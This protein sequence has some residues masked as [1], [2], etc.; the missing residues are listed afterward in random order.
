M[1]LKSYPAEEQGPLGPGERLHD[2]PFTLPDGR[3]VSLYA[4]RVFGWPVVMHVA[5]SPEAAAEGCAAL[6]DRVA[7]FAALEARLY[8]VTAGADADNGAL[9]E[10][11]G[12]PFPVLGDGGW[13]IFQALAHYRPA[14]KMK[15]AITLV[16]DPILRLDAVFDEPDAAQQCL[17]ALTW[18]Q[19]RR[20]AQPPSV[21]TAQPPALVVPRV[22]QPDQCQRL[23][24][25][26]EQGQKTEGY[27]TS[28]GAGGNV[29]KHRTKV[30]RDVV[31]PEGSA[32]CQDLIGSIGRRLL[33]EVL[34]GFGYR[35]T[36]IETPRIGCY[37]AEDG[38]HFAA[39][40]DNTARQAEY[41]RF[42]MSLNLNSGEYEGGYLRF[43]EFGPQLYA[44]EPGGAVVF[45]CSLL[46]LAMPVTKGRRLAVFSF[47]YGEEEEALR[48][49]LNQ[50]AA[51]ATA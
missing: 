47:F 31:L 13:G 45:C 42:A 51:R 39:H 32:E 11:L 34:K 12:L 35:V 29:V 3:T 36:R 7:D 40:R 18:L 9:V 27:V 26:W 38:G 50:E 33:P 8:G 1:H 44:P 48:Q 28:Q 25:F 20:A 17:R 22:L 19:A 21:V 24:R 4:T 46:H 30:R 16:F 41:R 2:L 10:R 15:Q 14:L 23:V 5:P 6:R 43:P 49:R 37:D